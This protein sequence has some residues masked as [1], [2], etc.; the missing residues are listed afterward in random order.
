MRIYHLAANV[1]Y[2]GPQPTQPSV[3]TQPTQ[4]NITNTS[5]LTPQQQNIVAWLKSHQGMLPPSVR[6]VITSPSITPATKPLLDFFI[7]MV[8]NPSLLSQFTTEAKQVRNSPQ[9]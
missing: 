7:A 4:Q 6:T 8:N 1:P 9:V 2:V 5:L 3:Q